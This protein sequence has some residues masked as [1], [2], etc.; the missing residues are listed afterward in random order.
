MT[1]TT[2][3]RIHHADGSATDIITRRTEYQ[4]LFGPTVH[5]DVQ[6]VHHTA[7]EIR[8][9]EKAG[10]V[11]TLVTLGVIAGGT[12]LHMLFGNKDNKK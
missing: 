8:E 7:Q 6:R 3:R 1:T 11:A 4:G 2:T 10:A 5:E 12:L 9:S